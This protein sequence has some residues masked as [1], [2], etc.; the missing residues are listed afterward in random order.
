[1]SETIQQQ[2]PASTQSSG[3]SGTTGKSAALPDN[4]TGLPAQLK[5]GMESVSGMDLSHVRVHYNSAKPAQLNAHAFAQGNNIHLGPGQE[6]HLP[7]ELGHVVQQAKGQVKPTTQF[8]GAKINDDPKLESE[9][10]AMG[11]QAMQTGGKAIQRAALPNPA[12]STEHL[13][14]AQPAQLSVVS[15]FTWSLLKNQLAPLGLNYI[16]TFADTKTLEMLSHYDTF[17]TIVDS[18][19]S[20]SNTL[21]LAVSIWERIPAPV[22]TGILFITGKALGY[23]PSQTAVEY[24]QNLLVDAD[25]GGGA[26]RLL[27]AVHLLKIAVDAANHPVS[28]AFKFGQ[29]LYSSWWDSAETT[30]K[31]TDE[32]KAE[33]PV[34]DRKRDLA[35]LDLHIIWVNVK[36]VQLEKTEKDDKGETK[37]RGGLHAAFGLGY[38]LF[39]HQGSIGQ[40]GGLV[41]ILPWEGGAI[42][43]SNEKVRL[44]NEIVFGNNFFVVKQL[45]MTMLHIDNKGLDKL[46]FSLKEFSVGNNFASATD[47]SAKYKRDDGLDFAGKLGVDILGW[48]A[49]ALLNLLLDDKG[50][51]KLAK[52]D[53]SGSDEPF[54]NTKAEISKEE[55]FELE[56]LQFN[57]K[58]LTGLDLAAGIDKLKVNQHITGKGSIKGSNIPLLG[59]KIKLEEVD[60]SLEVETEEWT[61]AANAIK[62]AIEFAKVNAGGKFSLRYNSKERK[63]HLKLTGGY[64][65]ANYD[66]F[67]VDAAELSYNHD[68]KKFDMEEALLTITA[69]NVKGDIKDVNISEHGVNFQSA[70]VSMKEEITLFDGFTLEQLKFIF[71]KNGSSLHL[72]SDALLK[73]A[74]VSASA[75]ALRI[76]FSGDGFDG[77]VESADLTTPIFG[78]DVKNANVSKEGLHVDEATLKLNPSR[79]SKDEAGMKDY[80]PSFNMGLLD[81]LPIGPVAFKI[82]GVDLNKAGLKIQSFRP[83]LD[84]VS[85]SAFG[86][87]AGIDLEEQYGELDVKKELSLAKLAPGLPLKVDVMF[88]IFPGLEAYGSLAADANLGIDVLLSGKGDE[89]KWTIGKHAMFTGG[90]N[91]TAELG[92]NAGSQLLVALSTGVFAKGEAKVEGKASISGT[93]KFNRKTRKFDAVKPF[94]IDYSFKPEAVASIGIVVK[95]KAFYFFEKKIFEY[96]AAEWRIGKYDLVGKIGNHDGEM[97]PEKPKKLGLEGKPNPIEHREI[98]GEAAEKMLQSDTPIAGSGEARKKLLQKERGAVEK[99]LQKLQAEHL[100]ASQ[101]LQSIA[102]KYVELLHKKDQYF[103]ALI[104]KLTAQQANAKLDEF[105]RKYKVEALQNQFAELKYKDEATEKAIQEH[106]Q[107]LAPLAAINEEHLE[108]QGLKQSLDKVQHAKTETDAL[109]I[110]NPES[111][112]AALDAV[113][114]GL[115]TEQEHNNV[116]LSKVS[117]VMSYREFVKFTTTKHFGGIETTRKTIVPVDT[118][119]AAF[120]DHQ[121]VGNLRKLLAAIKVY[122]SSSSSGRTPYVMLLET[123][124]KEALTVMEE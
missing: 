67:S 84:A 45:D 124:A 6:K 49:S 98:Q 16:L 7:H 39:S 79:T 19:T 41:L 46:A 97:A 54:K 110:E 108:T 50:E 55:G 61:A 11:S 38:R 9:A 13:N 89:G 71:G 69:L 68:E 42:L 64:F 65:H 99:Q 114:S 116:V 81:F 52:V 3:T 105:N 101:K 78:V 87:H 72:E 44:V 63:T 77:S 88:P 83:K 34:A 35:K 86:V 22:R 122:L 104:E 43:E 115:E 26:N 120:H 27:Q 85:L 91:V 15:D 24:S 30:K 58:E 111:F 32:K 80:V 66:G 14:N 25:H 37:K 76:G 23:L 47:V 56:S 36:S 119:L 109:G 82:T 90:V 31:P 100:K 117:A 102:K 103:H 18:V 59:D 28:S 29:Y 4:R 2:K 70:V 118:A 12:R 21:S 113:N 106:L 8:F 48:K 1:M 92:V 75:K 95:A 123:Q 74:K 60:G 51:F 94:V 40:T 121:S 73:R 112:E 62:L 5:A 57:L 33:E 53:M 17:Q 96:T 107:E 10:T 20:F 93:G